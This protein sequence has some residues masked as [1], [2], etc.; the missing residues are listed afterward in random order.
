MKR[1]NDFKNSSID[2]LNDVIDNPYK[3]V[4]PG[5][6]FRMGAVL[7]GG[8]VLL[9]IF[10]SLSAHWFQSTP[11]YAVIG[12]TVLFPLAVNIALLNIKVAALAELMQ[13]RTKP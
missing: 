2:E 9:K 1:L 13:R 7:G 4:T 12:F 11:D 8:L 10:S 3:V 6:I 5:I